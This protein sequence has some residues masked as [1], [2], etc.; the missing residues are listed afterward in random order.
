MRYNLFNVYRRDT[1]NGLIRTYAQ[2]LKLIF[3]F[4]KL[5]LKKIERRHHESNLEFQVI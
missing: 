1:V 3:L 5:I 4:I 2:N